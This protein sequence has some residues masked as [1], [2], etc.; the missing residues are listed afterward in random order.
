VVVN[1]DPSELVI[2]AANFHSL[3]PGTA[4]TPVPNNIVPSTRLTLS[5]NNSSRAIFGAA[6]AVKFIF[7]T[8]ALVALY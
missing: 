1:V 3:S 5:Y 6:C 4:F 2:L 8:V 7:S